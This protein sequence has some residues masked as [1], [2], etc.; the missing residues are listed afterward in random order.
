MRKFYVQ[1]TFFVGL[2][3]LIVLVIVLLETTE[4]VDIESV[5]PSIVEEQILLVTCHVNK[6]YQ[7]LGYPISNK[8]FFIRFIKN[9]S[10]INHKCFGVIC[11]IHIF[12]GD[13]FP[14]PDYWSARLGDENVGAREVFVIENG[15]TFDEID[16]QARH[17]SVIINYRRRIT[18][19]LNNWLLSM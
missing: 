10:Y 15:A 9:V 16:A 8:L 13:N 3:S 2:T 4:E 1:V 7:I 6:L 19:N 5:R 14:G 18:V 12:H 11:I 17:W